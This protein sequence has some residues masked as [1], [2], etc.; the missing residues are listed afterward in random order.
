M[1]PFLTSSS[2]SSGVWPVR[3]P[4][5]RS[6]GTESLLFKFGDRDRHLVV[7]LAA[8]VRRRRGPVEPTLLPDVHVGDEHECDEHGHLDQAE[9][10]EL[11]ERHCPREQ[12]DRLEGEDAE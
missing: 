6:T 1:T 5:N 2:T 11:A 4:S 12:E 3:C 10:P 7:H 8:E 9:Q